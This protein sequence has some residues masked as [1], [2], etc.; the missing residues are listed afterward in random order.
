[1]PFFGHE[2]SIS[3]C[4][5]CGIQDNM[6]PSVT[7]EVPSPWTYVKGLLRFI[8]IKI[9]PTQ[10]DT[11]QARQRVQVARPW[12]HLTIDIR[13]R[14]VMLDGYR[15][16]YNIKPVVR[17]LGTRCPRAVRRC[18][19]HSIPGGK[20]VDNWYEWNWFGKKWHGYRAQKLLHTMQIAAPI[21][22]GGGFLN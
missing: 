22:G 16:P 18:I 11:R 4:R 3:T 7:R 17:L 2:A 20:N 10:L 13:L 15:K 21:S 5:I 1:M 8:I 9:L 19:A 12:P 14:A 6:S